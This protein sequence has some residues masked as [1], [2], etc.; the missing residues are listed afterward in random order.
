MIVALLL[1]DAYGRGGYV[2]ALLEG[3]ELA[4][5]VRFQLP[6]SG[7]E[8]TLNHRAPA[9]D[10]TAAIL[11]AVRARLEELALDEAQL[12]ELT[13]RLVAVVSRALL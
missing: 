6:R 12:S 1:P 7:G 2:R 11:A 10:G 5:V 9:S 3:D 4:V 8:L 13:P